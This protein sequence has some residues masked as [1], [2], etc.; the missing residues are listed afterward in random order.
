MIRSNAM[1]SSLN[2]SIQPKVRTIDGLSV[3]YAESEQRDDHAILISPW[4]ESVFAYDQMWSRLAENTHLV[5]IDLP[6]FG[7]SERRNELMSPR[8]M[9][10]FLVRTADAF[11]LES[12][13]VVGPDVGT[14]TAL[15][16]AALHPGRLRSL[17]IGS[18]GAAFPLQLTGVLKDWVEDPDYE[19]YRAYDPR[20]VVEIALSTIEGYKVPDPIAADYVASYGGDRFFESMRYARAYPT[21]LPVL[22]ELLPGIQTPVQHIAGR[23]DGVVPVANSEYLQERLPHSKL[24]V[25]ES[26]HFTWE[27]APDEYAALV[28]SWWSGGY[29]AV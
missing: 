18:G 9:G 17:V 23:H 5:A 14:G 25:I 28:T 21:D 11:G 13:H 3:R 2:E 20:Q 7:Q 12:P 29:A 27:E 4:P 10:E 16:A 24:D 6:G 15:F 19:K 8:A 22:G 1:T 26:G